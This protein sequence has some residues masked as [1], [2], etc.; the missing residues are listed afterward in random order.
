MAQK[1]VMSRGMIG[2]WESFDTGEVH[3]R[4]LPKCPEKDCCGFGFY[5]R[6]IHNYTYARVYLY[7]CT[8]IEQT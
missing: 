6:Y 3:G 5:K 2:G 1:R 7:V 4:L 8:S